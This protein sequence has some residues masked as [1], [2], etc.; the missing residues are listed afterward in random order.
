MK[1]SKTVTAYFAT[2][3]YMLENDSSA[4]VIDPGEITPDLL[5]FVKANK[6]KSN[7]AILLTHCHFDHIAGATE[8]KMLF[9]ANVYISSIDAKGLDDP[10]INV[11]T[12]LTGNEFKTNADEV[13]NDGDVL[14]FGTD[15][16]KVML[17]PGHTAGSVCFIMDDIIFSGDTLFRMNIGRYDLPTS[18]PMQLLD[19]LNKIKKLKGNYTVYAG[20]GEA[21][22]L[23]FERKNNPYLKD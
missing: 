16:I 3:C 1:I 12:F 7:K 22:T 17:T 23:D 21:T 15:K 14:Q 2:N 18:N 6:N 11:S 10:N 20:H 8:L 19:S 4:I 5:G 13:F 9:D